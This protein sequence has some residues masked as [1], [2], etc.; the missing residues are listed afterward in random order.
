MARSSKSTT[1]AVSSSTAATTR[2]KAKQSASSTGAPAQ[3]NQSSRK[4]KKSWRKNVDIEDVEKGLEEMRKEERVVGKALQKQKD[5]DLFVIDTKGDDE[6]RKTVPK[7]SSLNLTS[8]K[9]LSQRSAVPAIISRVTSSSN[10]KKRKSPSSSAPLTKEDKERL[11]SIA[12][13]PR[14]GPFNAIM[15][16]NEYK[17]GENAMRLGLSEAVKQ[18]GGYD[19]WGG[20]ESGGVTI[21]EPSGGSAGKATVEDEADEEAAP[22]LIDSSN[23]DDGFAPPLPI[24]PKPPKH[25]KVPSARSLIALP[26]VSTPHAGASYNP[27][28][29]AHRELLIK[30]AEA[31]E[32]RVRELE[33]MG[34]V[35]KRIELLKEEGKFGDDDVD[36]SEGVPAGMKVQILS[37]DE[38]EEKESDDEDGKAEKKKKV[39]SR[40][41]KVQKNK[42][43]KVLEQKRLLAEKASIKKLL[44][45]IDQAK[46]LRKTLSAAERKREEEL[47]AKR[48]QKLEE[49]KTKG[50]AG[51][52]LGKH[53]VPESEMEV[54]VGE[55]LSENLRGLKPEGNL[56]RDRFQSLQQRALIEPRALVLPKKRRHRVVEYEKHAWK[57]F[58]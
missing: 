34:E 43:A 22:M 25:K 9:I 41:T 32:K 35:K 8:T 54:Q 26:S 24:A 57:K 15:D 16:P 17:P 5:E 55:D 11:L 53:R 39:A 19:P 52:K 58:E 2:S 1:T 47:E 31:E 38:G 23:A 50:L 10:S 13:R 21:I 18:S 33:K 49:L 27:P 44:S 3:H 29:E 12:K 36:E 14:K 45:S 51:M 4:G 28:E 46:S 30:A 56:F 40:K 7:F 48:L 37:D 20:I 6:I 42:A